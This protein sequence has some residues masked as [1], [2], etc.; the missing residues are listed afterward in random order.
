M[1][2]AAL[3]TTIVVRVVSVCLHTVLVKKENSRNAQYDL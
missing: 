3:V 2:V 1:D